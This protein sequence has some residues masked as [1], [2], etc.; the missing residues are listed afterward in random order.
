MSRY[1]L[2]LAILTA[3]FGEPVHA[4][5]VIV[6]SK[7]F[8]ENIIIAEIVSQLFQHHGV[9]AEHNQGLGGT[10]IL[11]DALVH[12]D[13]DVYPEYT[14]TLS[15]ELLAGGDARDLRLKLSDHGIAM[16]EPLG[17]NNSYVLG[18]TGVQADN[19]Q[20]KTITDLLIHPDLRFGFSNEFLARADGWPG[21]RDSYNLPQRNVT[22]LDHDLA[23]R[24]LIQGSLDVTDL[25]STDAEITY[26]GLR[27]LQDDR[28]YFPEYLAV[29]LYRQS[30][31]IER[32]E[33]PELLRGL[34]SRIAAGR[35]SD[36]NAAVKLHGVS[37]RKVAAAFLDDEF[38]I[39]ASADERQP[40]HDLY[41]HTLEHLQL[42]IISLLAAIVAGIPLGIACV[43]YQRSGRVILAV[44]GIIQTIPSLALLV[45]M[46]PL[47]G[48]GGP[49]AIAALFLYS[50]L[51]IIRN[52]YSGL[53][54][55][56]QP[57]LESA[58]AMGL[59]TAARMRLVELPLALRSIL[60]GIKVSA[61]I[62]VGT[63]TLG[64]LIGAGGYGQPIMT[65]I[66]LNDLSLILQGAI[67]A[68]ILALLVQGLFDVLEIILLPKRL[69][70][71]PDA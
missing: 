15:R 47:L 1:F 50:L 61:V 49:P 3:W 19:L 27:V 66:R 52:T 20:I 42:V 22:G 41:R 9:A 36:M 14:G 23:Y 64:A 25:Y 4:D 44:A 7:Q 58:L 29:L 59:P 54:D 40:L 60:S 26:Y 17:F 62:N 30:L 71:R 18:M 39:K 31:A 35:M 28:R 33:V 70:F 56:P 43:R 16:S 55:I 10:R 48:I 46:I 5:P 32:P 67:P 11:W 37:E 57:L 69:R 53:H 12:G 38:G 8:T 34:T 24:G 65:G 21:L 2:V 68:A 6:G 13:I 51:P 63:A 45:F